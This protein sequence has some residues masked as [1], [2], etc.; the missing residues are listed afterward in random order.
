M[1]SE[2]KGKYRFLSN[3]YPVTI[4]T[5]DGLIYP[6]VEHAY[7]ASKTFD[8]GERFKISELPTPGLAKKAGKSVKLRED[9][10]KIKLDVMYN[11]CFKKFVYNADLRHALLETEN[12]ELVEGNY[13]GDTFWGVCRGEGENHLGKIL[14]EIRESLKKKE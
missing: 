14:M 2:F 11:L 6:S 3:F 8:M 4:T 10:D 9:W 5:D 7:Q 1:I 13:W 12:E